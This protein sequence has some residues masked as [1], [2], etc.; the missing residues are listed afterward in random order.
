MLLNLNAQPT[1]VT[2]RFDDSPNPSCLMS[3]SARKYTIQAG[4]ESRAGSSI[5][6][7]GKVLKFAG[8]GVTLPSFAGL[9]VRCDATLLPPHS[10][11]WL[12]AQ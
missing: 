8:G 6:L 2:F 1:Y 10:V 3:K 9:L 4:P 12:V 11:T 7:N 5:L